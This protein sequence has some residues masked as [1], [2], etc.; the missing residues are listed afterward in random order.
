MEELFKLLIDI[1]RLSVYDA[2]FSD[3]P[4]RLYSQSSNLVLFCQEKQSAE[5]DP[6]LLRA[7][8][9]L[10]EYEAE[11]DN[12]AIEDLEYKSPEYRHSV[13]TLRNAVKEFCKIIETY[14]PELPNNAD[15]TT[16]TPPKKTTTAKNKPRKTKT[17]MD[18][19]LLKDDDQKQKLLN[20][21]H[22]LIDGEIGRRVALV[23]LVCVKRGLLK[24]K[25]SYTVMKNAFG[26]IGAKSGYDDQY[27]MGL[28]HYTEEEIKG[29]EEYISKAF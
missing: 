12:V 17:I 22:D 6:I 27:S 8:R 19:M 9:N 14:Y 2:L 11:W 15:A 7:Y 3:I 18:F 1:T 24:S 5:P 4:E 13:S 26:N 28:K 23:I 21:L 25:P 29:I 16:A 20:V 10:Q